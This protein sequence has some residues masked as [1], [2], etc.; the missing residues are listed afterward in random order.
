MTDV[1][2]LT[3]YISGGIY[4]SLYTH[5]VSGMMGIKRRTLYALVYLIWFLFYICGAHPRL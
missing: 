4:M 3:P 5:T 1:D 2:S